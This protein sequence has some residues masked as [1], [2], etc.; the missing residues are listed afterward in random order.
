MYD[1]SLFA[2]P[3]TNRNPTY[4]QSVV[5]QCVKGAT[6]TVTVLG[7]GGPVPTPPVVYVAK[8]QFEQTMDAPPATFG[9]LLNAPGYPGINI[10]NWDTNST[11]FEAQALPTHPGD[12]LLRFTAIHGDKIITAYV[13]V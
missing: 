9:F 6:I 7:V 5:W 10:S 12:R 2:Q 1:L 4:E 8:P 13:Y 3:T 11:M